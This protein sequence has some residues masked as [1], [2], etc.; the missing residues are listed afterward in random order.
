MGLLRDRTRFWPHGL[1]TVEIRQVS[2]TPDTDHTDIGFIQ[3]STIEDLYELEKRFD[4]IGNLTNVLEKS[5]AAA[6]RTKLMQVGID[7]INLIKNSKGMK[8]SLR[9]RGISKESGRFQY[10][11]FDQV[12]LNRSL[13][14]E[15]KTGP[16]T[17][18][19][20]AFAIDLSDAIGVA[21]PVGY[22]YESAGQI[23]TAGLQLWLDARL[24]YGNATAAALE[25]SGFARHGAL[26]NFATIWQTGSNPDRFLRLNGSSDEVNLGN[27]LNDD[28]SGDFI[29]E[30]WFAPKGSN[31]VQEELLT[32]KSLVSDNT[33]G[34]AVYRTSGNLMAFRIGSGSASAMAT[35]S[36]TCLQNTNKHFAVT[37]DR[38]G[39]A[40]TYLNGAADG[41]PVSVA[42][43]GTGTNALNLFL[44]HD[45]T[46]YGQFDVTVVRIY[47]YLTGGLPA[48]A[49]TMIANHYNAERAYFG[50]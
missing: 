6:V 49:A 20:E 5:H 11:A 23:R 19:F 50:L 13:A 12:I 14:R 16:L 39:N 40:Q 27:V 47:R 2:P 9:Y 41:S 31:G 32:K 38:N 28:A 1:G 4:E 8:W 3:E 25:I 21:D 7:E 34:F 42:A 15:F 44:G 43:I 24:G 17:I 22:V 36:G 29:I 30:I 10:N 48:D 37:V 33:A 18:P 45:G 46:N 35:T 26:N